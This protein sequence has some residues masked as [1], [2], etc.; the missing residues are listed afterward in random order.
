MNGLI[1]IRDL[2]LNANMCSEDPS[3][4]P[5]IST[6]KQRKIKIQVPL[7]NAIPSPL[8]DNDYLFF[9]FFLFLFSYF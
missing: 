4:V 5:A 6:L 8:G 1:Q 2:T 3:F 7:P 9:F